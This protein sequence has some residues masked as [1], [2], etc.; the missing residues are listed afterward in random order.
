MGTLTA[1]RIVDMKELSNITTPEATKSWNPIPHDFL[2]KSV[3][4]EIEA[5]EDFE[6][7]SDPQIGLSHN[8][9]RCFFLAELKSDHSDFCLSIGGRNAHDKEFAIGMFGGAGVFICSNLQAFSE[10]ALKTKHTAH[11]MERLPKM[12]KDG[13]KEIRIDGMVNDE[14]INFYK[15]YEID[16]DIIVHDYLIKSMDKNIIP[17]ASIS[18]VLGEWR[19]PRHEEFSPRNMWS[20][21]NCYTEIFK[22][23]NN[24][25]Q[26][27][28][29]SINLTKVMD[30]WTLFDAKEV[31]ARLVPEELIDSLPENP[32]P[33]NTPIVIYEATEEDGS[34][35]VVSD[36]HL[37][38]IFNSHAEAIVE[39]KEKSK[40]K[41]KASKAKTGK[42]LDKI[43]ADMASERKAKKNPTLLKKR[44]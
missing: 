6:L 42:G 3:L 14:R 18:K 10:Y 38:E 37:Q 30:E 8:G 20:F 28:S 39:V 40:P 21:N 32:K 15:D 24:P 2:V 25:E 33:E 11:V 16:S 22:E 35:E 27:N 31:R 19:K 7:A 9:A 26:L 13:L 23:Y 29:R 41:K 17:T 34:A 44:K 4:E 1:E 5:M 43:L 36:T 12:I